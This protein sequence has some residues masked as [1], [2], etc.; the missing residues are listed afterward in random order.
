MIRTLIFKAI[1][2]FGRSLVV[3]SVCLSTLTSMPA[4]ASGVDEWTWPLAGPTR[5]VRE[6]VAPLN[7]YGRGHRGI[8]LAGIV[9]QPVISPHAGV[10]WFSGF[11]VNRGV[12]TIRVD[13]GLLLSFEPVASSLT[14]GESVQK[15]D[16]IGLLQSGHC[17]EPCLH[18]GI[19]RDGEYVSP[20][21]YLGGEK[22]SI[23]LPTRK[24]L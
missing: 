8:D 11:V 21:L 15:G 13:G 4:S 22:R 24:W 6:F 18:F 12:L 2:L 20:L 19:R 5:V 16:Q 7:P 9:E 23:L 10:V 14:V 3:A 17:S 1:T